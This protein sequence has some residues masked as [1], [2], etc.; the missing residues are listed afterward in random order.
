MAAFIEKFGV[1]RK[2]YMHKLSVPLITLM[3]IDSPKVIYGKL[4]K[5]SDQD[6]NEAKERNSKMKV[7][8]FSLD[9]LIN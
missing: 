5:Y 7:T 6:M 4:K 3:A 1:S 8:T 9:E 2:E